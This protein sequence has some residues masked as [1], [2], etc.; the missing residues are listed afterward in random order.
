MALNVV[1]LFD[2][3]AQADYA[4]RQLIAAGIDTRFI[5]IVANDT[6]GAIRKETVDESGNL[7]SAGAISGAT[8][9][10][11]VGGLIGLLVGATA[12]AVPPLGFVVAGPIAG[13][14]TGAGVGMVSGGLMGALIGLG[15]PEEEA[16]I[17]AESVRR[18]GTLVTVSV[19]EVD[20]L[21]VEQILSMSGA[22]NIQERA[23]LYRQTGFTAYDP[24]APVYTHDQVIAERQR[25]GI[26]IPATSETIVT[27]DPAVPGEA[28]VSTTNSPEPPFTSTVVGAVPPV[29]TPGSTV[30]E[31]TYLVPDSIEPSFRKHFDSTFAST[32]AT[33]ETYRPAYRFG[34]ELAHRAEFR[35][36]SWDAARAQARS[37]WE[38]T[39][40]GTWDRYSEAVRYGW[41]NSGVGST[42]SGASLI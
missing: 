3:H 10:L 42:S 27:T 7:A 12:L 41:D 13:L 9:G 20:R 38:Q 37:L 17:Y 32:G 6:T 8:S 4:V 24:N 23:G 28:Y 14:I 40:P 15:V 1:G 25:F 31:E 19:E 39:N 18:G 26:P 5:S 36:L 33:Y 2:T 34:I 35:N 16:H 11:L 21:R 29:A 22:V 30:V